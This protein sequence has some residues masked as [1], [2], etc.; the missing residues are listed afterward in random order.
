MSDTEAVLLRTT[1]L[2]ESVRFYRDRLGFPVEF[3]DDEKGI[4]QIQAPDGKRI[5]I[6]REEVQDLTPWV[7]RHYSTAMPGDR[8]TLYLDYPSFQQEIERKGIPSTSIRSWDWGITQVDVTDPNGYIFSFWNETP[9]PDE[10]IQFWYRIGPEHLRRILEGLFEADLDLR[11]NVG[12]KTI[13][14]IALQ[15]ID[16]DAVAAIQTLIALAQ[17]GEIYMP[18]SLESDVWAKNL[19]YSS[20]PVAPALKLFEAIRTRILS[21]ID[22]IPG[23]LDRASIAEQGQPVTVRE[24]IRRQAALALQNVEQIREILEQNNRI[25]QVE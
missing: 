25:S 20:Q 21:L 7:E 3:E 14:E 1:D 13:R 5:F 22:R 17:P 6:V 8:V 10:K 19:L 2:A 12:Q 18:N 15:T 16:Q 24:L 11:K 9:L 4:A 23:A